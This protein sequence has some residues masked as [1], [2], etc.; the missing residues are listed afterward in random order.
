MVSIFV[1]TS[2]RVRIVTL[3]ASAWERLSRVPSRHT[4][5]FILTVGTIPSAR[6]KGTRPDV[7]LGGPE[8]APNRKCNAGPTW[9]FPVIGGV[10]GIL[11]LLHVRGGDMHAPNAVE[12]MRHIQKKHF[13]FA[14]SG[15]EVVLT[16]GA[17]RLTN[18]T[19]KWENLFRAASPALLIILGA[20]LTLY[21]E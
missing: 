18:P 20:L 16:N 1:L 15:F 6:Y 3:G 21:K 17:A 11:L 7:S 4:D 2:R 9:L 12:S 5:L 14:A 8:I 10:G 13:W 19:Q